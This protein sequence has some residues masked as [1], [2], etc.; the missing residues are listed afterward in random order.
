MKT[1]KY[2][3]I[4]TMTTHCYVYKQ[5]EQPIV[6]LDDF[7]VS[8]VIHITSNMGTHDLSDVYALSPRVCS[9]WALSIH[10]RQTRVTTITCKMQDVLM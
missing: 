1:S 5:T 6:S 4:I 2:K 8:E 7:R 3:P 10:I 9:P